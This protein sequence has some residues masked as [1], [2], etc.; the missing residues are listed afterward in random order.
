[1]RVGLIGWY[2]HNN[3][4]DERILYS[5]VK[6]F[7]QMEIIFT[8]G[9]EDAINRIDE[10]NQCDWVLL[11]GGG[12]VLRRT[13][14]YAELIENLKPRFGCLGL[15]IETYHRDNAALIDV[16]D[17]KSEFILVRD[18]RSRSLIGSHSK[19]IVGPDLTFLYPFEDVKLADNNICGVNLRPWPY[20][21]GEFM[22]AFD[23]FM[24]ILDYHFH[25]LE[26]IYPFPRWDV[27]SYIN[28]LHRHFDK[29]VPIPLYIDSGRPSDVDVLRRVSPNFSYEFDPII[30][31]GCR[32]FVGM[33]LHSII[34][35]C[36]KGIPFIS[37]SYQPKNVQFC[38]S[39]NLLSCSVD[40]YH[41]DKLRIALDN[42]V[43]ASDEIRSTL[44]DASKK[45]HN[46]ISDIMVEVLSLLSS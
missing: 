10:L 25:G 21:Q 33:R 41:P 46:E 22:G 28:E 26:K 2:G 9:W 32:Y 23:R 17:R 19:V 44:S 4:G 39:L 42:L 8:S 11:G 40:L 24:S 6:F 37:L 43:H 12:L 36:Q 7:N 35:A 38:K 1:M 5:I 14:R 3:A 18:P 34:F 13:G 30:Y 45:F 15:S 27:N 31:D 20:W 16:L 29:L